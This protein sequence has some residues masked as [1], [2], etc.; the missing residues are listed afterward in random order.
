[1][2]QERLFPPPSVSP[3][4]PEGP[5]AA[6]GRERRPR[7][8]GVFAALIPMGLR[9]SGPLPGAPVL[10]LGFESRPSLFFGPERRGGTRTSRPREV[11]T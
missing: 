9:A 7:P 6:R 2:A 1:M 4:L 3:L 11:S 10:P 8:L 5:I